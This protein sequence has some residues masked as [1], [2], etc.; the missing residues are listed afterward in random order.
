MTANT[1][2]TLLDTR[3]LLAPMTT[4]FAST[5]T[6]GQCCPVTLLATPET[7]TTMASN[8][9]IV[10]TEQG[11]ADEREKDRNAK[12][13]H[14]IHPKTLHVKTERILVPMQEH[15]P[16]PLRLPDNGKL[17]CLQDL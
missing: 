17:R 14:S 15:S 11:D 2:M 3:T 1:A 5:M 4:Q 12:K 13:N 7:M 16:E 8:Y 10:T 6:L 9:K